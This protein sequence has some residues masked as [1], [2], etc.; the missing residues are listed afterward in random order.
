M[1]AFIRLKNKKKLDPHNTQKTLVPFLSCLLLLFSI[2]VNAQK[3]NNISQEFLRKESVIEE[4]EKSLYGEKKPSKQNQE[5]QKKSDRLK[6]KIL[7]N[8]LELQ[9]RD[10]ITSKKISLCLISTKKNIFWAYKVA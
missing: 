7:E 8:R 6:R 9:K 5:I 4:I 10:G 2:T 1:K 3:E